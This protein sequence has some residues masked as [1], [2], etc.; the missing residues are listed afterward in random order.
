M[1]SSFA[2]VSFLLPPAL[3]VAH[4]RNLHAWQMFFGA[5]LLYPL[6]YYLTFSQVLYRHVLEPIL[7]LL[8]AYAGVEALSKLT[9]YVRSARTL[10]DLSTPTTIEPS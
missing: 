7:L 5:F 4:R 2:V 1:P 3:L 8:M 10:D 6:A 9:S